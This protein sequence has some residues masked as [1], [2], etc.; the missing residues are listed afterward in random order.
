MYILQLNFKNLSQLFQFLLHALL[1]NFHNHTV[2]LV[3]PYAVSAVLTEICKTQLPF[4]F[5]GLCNSAVL[6]SSSKVYEGILSM[7]LLYRVTLVAPW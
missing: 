5:S 7:Y 1:S 3:V 6:Q 4:S 2:Q